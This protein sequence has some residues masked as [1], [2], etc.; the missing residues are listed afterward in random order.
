MALIGLSEAQRILGLSSRGT[1]HRKVQSGELSSV[2]GPRGSRL[3]E[4]D[5]LAERWAEI[6]REKGRHVD[7]GSSAAAPA[8]RRRKSRA[9][10]QV[11]NEHD[12]EDDG[13][14]IDYN[15]ERGLLTREQRKKVQQEREKL[16]LEILEKS[17]ELVYREDMEKAYSAVLLQL[18]TR[19]LAVSKLI[20]TDIPELTD[21]QIEK[22]EQRL[23]DVFE[24]AAE[25]DYEELEES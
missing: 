9:S 6:V 5:G 24:G 13:E 25:H 18:T 4:S 21:K 1:L 12:T 17:G 14:K 19:G 11:N 10:A 23:A 8:A 2:D 3:V 7:V 16:R 20:K 22:I 15:R